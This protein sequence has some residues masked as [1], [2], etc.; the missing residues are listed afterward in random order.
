M[1]LRKRIKTIKDKEEATKII[2]ERRKFKKFNYL[3]HNPQNRPIAIAKD[4]IQ[5]HNTNFKEAQ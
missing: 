5:Q 3:K 1:N 4:N 2:L